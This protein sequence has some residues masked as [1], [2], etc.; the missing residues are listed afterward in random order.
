MPVLQVACPACGHA[1]EVPSNELSTVRPI[2]CPE[3]TERINLPFLRQLQR[4]TVTS[5]TDHTDQNGL[6]VK[7]VE[8]G[9]GTDEFR[10]L[11]MTHQFRSNSVDDADL[12]RVGRH[13]LHQTLSALA[14]DT[15]FW[16][17]DDDE[18]Q[19]LEQS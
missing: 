17:L 6:R 14:E 7:R 3:C 5:I 1:F 12:V 18:L 13:Y 9:Y 11:T 15:V 4:I 19:R 10:R 2:Q 16:A 8:F